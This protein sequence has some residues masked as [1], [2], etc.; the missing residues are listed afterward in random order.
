VKQLEGGPRERVRGSSLVDW[1]VYPRLRDTMQASTRSRNK[2]MQGRN[3]PDRPRLGTYQRGRPRRGLLEPG[4]GLL[5]RARRADGAAE[6]LAQVT[7]PGCRYFLACAISFRPQRRSAASIARRVERRK[8]DMGS[9]ELSGGAG[10][11]RLG[12]ADFSRIRPFGHHPPAVNRQGGFWA[13]SRPATAGVHAI[14]E[15]WPEI[16]ERTAI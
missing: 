10:P 1:P 7:R 12:R 3:F 5:R 8:A 16:A 4:A 9:D 13:R 6:T 11:V 15:A 14:A 2:P